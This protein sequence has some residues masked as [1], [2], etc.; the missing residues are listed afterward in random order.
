MVP[1]DCWLTLWIPDTWNALLFRKIFDCT[2]IFFKPGLLRSH[3]QL[4]HRSL[5]SRLMEFYINVCRYRDHSFQ[6]LKLSHTKNFHTSL[7]S[8]G[9]CDKNL[10][11]SSSLDLRA[12]SK[13][14][15]LIINIGCGLRPACISLLAWRL[16]G[17]IYFACTWK[18]PWSFHG[19]AC[20]P[21]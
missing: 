16:S 3:V 8:S 14:V 11:V 15:P 5:C 17:L 7:R 6:N 18:G 9:A 12:E 2:K 19:L 21:R 1:E 4:S 10:P 13:I 20:V